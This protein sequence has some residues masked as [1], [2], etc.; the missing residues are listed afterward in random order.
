MYDDY[1]A[2]PAFN[3]FSYVVGV[4]AQLGDLFRLNWENFD[5]NI[6]QN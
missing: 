4:V 1:L 6:E 3:L 2:I 5:N